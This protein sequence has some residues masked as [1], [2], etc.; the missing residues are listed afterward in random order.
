[1]G[2]NLSNSY[3]ADVARGR[4]FG[5]S[6]VHKFGRN[7]DV[8]TAFEDIWETGGVYSWPTS[9]ST[10]EA[11]STD[12]N[13]TAAGTGARTVTIEG[14]DADF[15]EI[16]E[17]ITMNGVSASSA[18]ALSF[19]RVNRAY[20]VQSG[21]Y[22]STTSGSNIGNITIRVSG[23]G[24]TQATIQVDALAGKGQTEIARYTVPAG[25]V[26]FVKSVFINVDSTKNAATIAFFQRRSADT[27]VAPFTSK[28]LVV[29]FDGVLGETALAPTTPI[30]PFPAKTDLWFAAHAGAAGNNPEVEVD[31]E[32]LLYDR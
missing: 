12:A 14:L 6:V 9:A 28:R 21:A 18:T 15:N 31:F 19:L 26:A 32:I 7:S 11:I 20:V 24:A 8:G 22:S 5:A 25:K 2:V 23:A 4:I 27:I 3:Y 13:D 29:E 30:G 10:L 1:M 17:T 16:S